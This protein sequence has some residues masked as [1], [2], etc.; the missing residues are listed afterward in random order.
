MWIEYSLI[1]K[2]LD[3]DTVCNPTKFA[4]NSKKINYFWAGENQFI[5]CF[6]QNSQPHMSVMVFETEEV[7]E[8]IYDAFKDA[9]LGRTTNLERLGYV[10]PLKM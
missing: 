2:S 8:R 9:L 4:L 6:S 3:S 1:Y 7:A 10:A 5:I